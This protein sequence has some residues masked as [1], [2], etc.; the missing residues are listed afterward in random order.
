MDAPQAAQRGR[1]FPQPTQNR[2]LSGL[3]APHAAQS[4]AH[5]PHLPSGDRRRLMGIVR[6]GAPS[7]L[8]SAERDRVVGNDR[9]L[10]PC[11]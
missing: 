2:A 6:D 3:S 10:P 1:L 5:S 4:I 8:L 7:S 9:S 11:P